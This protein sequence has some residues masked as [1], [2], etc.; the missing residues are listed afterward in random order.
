MLCS[1]YNAHFCRWCCSCHCI[2]NLLADLQK[3]LNVIVLGEN[4]TIIII[5]TEA[6]STSLYVNMF[7]QSICTGINPDPPFSPLWTEV[8]EFHSSIEFFPNVY[9]LYIYIYISAAAVACT[10]GAAAYCLYVLPWRQGQRHTHSLVQTRS[11]A[12][13][14]GWHGFRPLR[15]PAAVSGWSWLPG[16]P[17]G[18]A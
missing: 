10:K 12:A 11:S 17:P 16:P 8:G 14:A 13:T 15:R 1:I 3:D 6:Y 18:Q 9:T 2:E 7:Q 4:I 5:S